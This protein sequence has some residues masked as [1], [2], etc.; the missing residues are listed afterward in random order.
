MEQFGGHQD[1]LGF[2]F[3]IFIYDL[4]PQTL[5]HEVQ[6]S[7]CKMKLHLSS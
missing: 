5:L 7:Y 4:D 6:Q 2:I 1:N 3:V